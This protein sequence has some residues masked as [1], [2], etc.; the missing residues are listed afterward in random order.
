MVSEKCDCL[1]EEDLFDWFGEVKPNSPES[2]LVLSSSSVSPKLPVSPV[3]PASL[4]LPPTL[5]KPASSS[6]LS[7]LVP[8][9]LSAHPQSA[10]SGCSDPPQAFQFP[11]L[12]DPLSAPPAS[13]A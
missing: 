2:L 6:A 11:A 9:S 3:F 7:L 1:K 12:E 4:P 13:E 8:V 5:L 10:P